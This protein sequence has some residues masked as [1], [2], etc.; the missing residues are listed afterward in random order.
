MAMHRSVPCVVIGLLLLSMP[1]VSSAASGSP[2]PLAN[3]DIASSNRPAPSLVQGV[4]VPF[5][6]TL[7][8]LASATHSENDPVEEM[9]EESG[10]GP[11]LSLER[12]P[13]DPGERIDGRALIMGEKCCGYEMLSS[14]LLYAEEG[15]VVIAAND[16]ER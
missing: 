12:I 8:V 2:G 10:L 14:H 15:S 11:V 13:L 6:A 7:D 5:G 9:D 3:S 1:F 16:G 4:S